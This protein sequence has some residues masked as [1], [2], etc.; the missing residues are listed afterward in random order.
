MFINNFD[1]VAFE[2]FLLRS[3]GIHYHIFFGLILG[4]IYCNKILIKD[5]DK[6]NK[7]DD[8]ITFLIIGI[9]VGGRI[10]YVFSTI[11]LLLIKI[12]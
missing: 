11:H 3:D 6:K 4:W 2:Y 7:F 12:L 9:I 1:P 10:G 8:Y 5:K